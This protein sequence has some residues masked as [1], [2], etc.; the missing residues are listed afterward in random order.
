MINV[1][2]FMGNKTLEREFVCTKVYSYKKGDVSLNFT[3]HTDKIS[4][5]KVFLKMLS[6]A[7]DD[8]SSDIQEITG[9]EEAPKEV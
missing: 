9:V 6:T 3:L 5:M 7:V 1:I 2:P 8:V 4:E